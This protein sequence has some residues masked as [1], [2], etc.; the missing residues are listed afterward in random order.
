MIPKVNPIVVALVAAYCALASPIN[1]QPDYVQ[2]VIDALKLQ[3]EA[4]NVTGGSAMINEAEKYLWDNGVLNDEVFANLKQE[5]EV[6]KRT[7]FVDQS[8]K[9]FAQTFGGV[10]DMFDYLLTAVF[11]QSLVTEHGIS[12]DTIAVDTIEYLN[13]K[14]AFEKSE[15]DETGNMTIFLDAA[16]IKQVVDH[17]VSFRSCPDG[18]QAKNCGG[19]GCTIL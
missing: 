1:T 2:E 9:P 17:G 8:P 4:D 6:S 12:V 19:L 11:S 16:V 3:L 14:G 7:C 15:D 18:S 5:I 13:A 10:G